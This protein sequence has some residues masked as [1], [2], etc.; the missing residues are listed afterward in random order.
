MISNYLK[1]INVR[2]LTQNTKG[3]TAE[4]YIYYIRREHGCFC[5]CTL[6]MWWLCI[7][8]PQSLQQYKSKTCSKSDNAFEHIP[9][10]SQVC[11]LPSL[12]VFVVLGYF[13]RLCRPFQ[14]TSLDLTRWHKAFVDLRNPHGYNSVYVAICVSA[15]GLSTGTVIAYIIRVLGIYGTGTQNID[16]IIDTTTVKYLI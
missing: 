4:E 1:I 11:Q 13:L 2:Y 14:M 7:C 12:L 8:Q 10:T 15:D 5:H 16:Y 3:W 9:T 6:L